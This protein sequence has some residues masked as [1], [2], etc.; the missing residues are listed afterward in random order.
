MT[1]S[2][3]ILISVILL[4]LLAGAYGWFFIYNKAH[5]DYS[6]EEPM[7]IL[8]PEE[9]FQAFAN[10][11]ERSRKWL[12]QVLQ[13]EGMAS[14]IEEND[15]L[16]IIVFVVNEEGMFG[17]EG[18]RCSLRNDVNIQQTMLSSNIKVKGYC[19]GFNES[20]VILEQAVIIN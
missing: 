17:P 15:S 5:T 14:Q 18:I 20:D 3:K 16:Q 11:E 9:C 12:G 8:S 19:T 13:I 2:K 1:T 7:A 6:Q 10:Q 4:A